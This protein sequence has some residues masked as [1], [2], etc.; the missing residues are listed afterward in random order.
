MAAPI[1][2]TLSHESHTRVSTCAFCRMATIKIHHL[3][4]LNSL[5]PIWTDS[6]LEPLIKLF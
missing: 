1:L 4:S 5:I 6:G 3:V 2:T